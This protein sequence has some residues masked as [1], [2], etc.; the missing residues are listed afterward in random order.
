MNTRP[1]ILTFSGHY[2]NFL[3]PD[4]AT[5]DIEDI[6]QGLS[7][8]CRFA[9]QSRRYYSVAQHSVHVAGLVAELG[10]PHHALAGLLHDA[11][12]AYIGDVT[13]P[14]KQLLPDY[15]QIES[16]VEAAVFARF[17]LPAVLQPVVKNADLIMLATEQR[18]LMAPHDDR[19]ACIYGIAPLSFELQPWSQ[20]YAREVF[21]QQFQKLRAQEGG[22]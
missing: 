21:L 9:G 19:W 18:D 5:I 8:V 13:R 17:G 6:A 15:R 22:V 3:R 1:D 7:N 20:E 10:Y 12:E 4:P 16:R 2:F 11:A 14:L